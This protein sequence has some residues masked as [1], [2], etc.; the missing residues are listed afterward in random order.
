MV[1]SNLF[2]VYVGVACKVKWEAFIQKF[3]SQPV[4]VPGTDVIKTL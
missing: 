3:S 4:E 1:S 2:I